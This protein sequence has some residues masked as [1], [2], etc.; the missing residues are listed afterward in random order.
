[1][2]SKLIARLVVNVCLLRRREVKTRF[3]IFVLCVISSHLALRCREV[4]NFKISSLIL[5]NK[6]D[7]ESVPAVFS[8]RAER[9]V[10]KKKSR[11]DLVIKRC[12]VKLQMTIVWP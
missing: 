11:R 5:C 3:K 12:F 9:L 1:M 8:E 10:I 2:N 4:K 7:N 6:C